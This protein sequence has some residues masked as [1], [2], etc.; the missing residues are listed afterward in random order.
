MITF[1]P[2]AGNHTST[3][4]EFQP[5]ELPPGELLLR[6]I[7]AFEE[8]FCLFDQRFPTNGA[9]AA[10]ITGHTTVQQWRDAPRRSTAAPTRCSLPVLTQR[11]TA[12]LIFRRVLWSLIRMLTRIISLSI[13]A[14]LAVPLLAQTSTPA[15][16]VS[17]PTRTAVRE[18]IGSILVDG[19]AYEYDRELADGIGPRLTGSANYDR[20]VAWSM[21]QF[22]SLG[23]TNVHTESFYVSCFMGA[24]GSSDRDHP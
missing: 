19:K 24:R 13:A 23:L 7:G 1:T 2:E 6:P 8:L 15:N 14:A 16:T 9:L 10:Q 11:L 17:E 21:D 12:S 18:L 20:A 3:S 5:L 4:L 22:R